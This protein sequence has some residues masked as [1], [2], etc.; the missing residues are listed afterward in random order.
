VFAKEVCHNQPAYPDWTSFEKELQ[1]QFLPLHERTQAMN[2]L[3]STAYYQ[4]KQMVDVYIDK[5]E[6]LVE[7]AGYSEG[8]AIV[9]KFQV[10]L[11]PPTQSCIVN[12]L[13]N[14][15]PDDQPAAWYKAA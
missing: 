6:V 2:T 10:G 1:S 14:C 12:M 7:Q 4:A 15:P 9:M 3:E 13:E 5:F 11:D 8:L